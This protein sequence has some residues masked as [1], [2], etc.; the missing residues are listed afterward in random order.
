MYTCTQY[1]FPCQAKILPGHLGYGGAAAVLIVVSEAARSGSVAQ[2]RLQSSGLTFPSS[3]DRLFCPAICWSTSFLQLQIDVLSPGQPWNETWQKLFDR[4]PR[5][6]CLG[7]W[8]CISCQPF[9]KLA[10]GL[11]CV[12]FIK[13]LAAKSTVH[14]VLNKKGFRMF[15]IEVHVA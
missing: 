10:V 1:Y 11:H 8:H 15:V 4:F 7:D 14:F 3:C 9:E 6:P 2:K 13:I 12:R 5:S